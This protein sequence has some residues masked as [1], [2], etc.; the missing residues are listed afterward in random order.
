MSLSVNFLLVLSFIIILTAYDIYLFIYKKQ[1][2]LRW[3]YAPNM[4]MRF[5]KLMSILTI[6]IAVVSFII[7]WVIIFLILFT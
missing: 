2:P 7:S 1:M 3:F 6:I 4:N 5:A